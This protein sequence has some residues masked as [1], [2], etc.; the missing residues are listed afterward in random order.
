MT[1]PADAGMSALELVIALGVAAGLFVV[2]AGAMPRPPAEDGTDPKAIAAFLS[3]ARSKAILSGVAALVEIKPGAM[4]SGDRRIDWKADIAVVTETASLPT[5]YRL[6]AYPD[7][8]YSGG[9]LRIRSAGE[10]QPIPGVFT[11][12]FDE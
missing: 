6:F 1:A 12:D 9:P 3:E 7:G 10:M 5:E 2:I 4:V 8:R 11:G